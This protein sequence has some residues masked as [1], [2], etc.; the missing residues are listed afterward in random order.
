MQNKKIT[1][2]ILSEEYIVIDSLN[3]ITLAD[4]FLKNKNGSGH[5]EAKLYVGNQSDTIN[6][7]F[8]NFENEKTSAFFLKNDLLKM[9]NDLED[10][11]KTPQQKYMKKRKQQ[12]VDITD[13]MPLLWNSHINTITSLDD[14][15]TFSFF[16]SPVNPPRVYINSNDLSWN[17][18]RAIGIPNISYCSILKLQDKDGLITYYF[19]PFI[20]YSNDIKGYEYYSSQIEIQ[21]LKKIEQSDIQSRKKDSLKASRI[22]QGKYREKLLEDM[23]YCPFTKINDERI[24]IASHIKPWVKSDN[25]EKIDCKN[26]LTLSPTYD[27]L[28]DKGFITFDNAGK[29]IVSQFISPMNQKRL[30]IYTGKSIE[31]DRF[32]NEERLYYLDYHRKYVFNGILE[33]NNQ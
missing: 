25:K 1:A 10:E 23:P 7:F 29:L 4:S 3:N 8:S 12:L 17:Y 9:L 13:E 31:L 26:G 2:H 21:E 27:A 30:N 32:L 11:Y 22:G 6:D 24:L 5:G 14:M 20:D 15:L 28:F 16:R 18:L 19:K 33:I